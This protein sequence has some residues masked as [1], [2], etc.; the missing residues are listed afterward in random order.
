MPK[1]MVYYF[2]LAFNFCK[3]GL[4]SCVCFYVAKTLFCQ[5]DLH[6]VNMKMSIHTISGRNIDVKD[7]ES[8]LCLQDKNMEATIRRKK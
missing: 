6:A 8:F 2:Q 5:N 1:R 7:M 4:W 3:K